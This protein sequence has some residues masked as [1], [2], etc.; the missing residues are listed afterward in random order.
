LALAKLARDIEIGATVLFHKNLI[1]SRLEAQ[2]GD[3]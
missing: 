2:A 1:R 3:A